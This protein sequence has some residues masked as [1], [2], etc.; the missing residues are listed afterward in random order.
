M[1]DLSLYDSAKLPDQFI[2]PPETGI[3]VDIGAQEAQAMFLGTM[4]V[5]I[6]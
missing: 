3:S 6:R 1:L 2:N 4:C 5:V